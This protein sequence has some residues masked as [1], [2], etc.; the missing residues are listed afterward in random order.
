MALATKGQKRPTS[1]MATPTASKAK[2]SVK[3]M[4]SK[5]EHIFKSSILTDLIFRETDELEEE[6][7]HHTRV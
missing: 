5:F 1:W 6:K 3:A 7:R 4:V 2:K